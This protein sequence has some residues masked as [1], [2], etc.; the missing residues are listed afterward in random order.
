MIIFDNWRA[1]GQTRLPAF[2]QGSL[3]P[4]ET[5][6]RVGTHIYSS[7]FCSELEIEL[8]QEPSN[9]M[10]PRFMCGQDSQKRLDAL[11]N[12]ESAMVC[13]GSASRRTYFSPRND[14]SEKV[15]R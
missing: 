10:R 5:T 3:L 15:D 2:R 8:E 14:P 6:R 9:W 1:R 4:R 13:D 11:G 7:I 12:L